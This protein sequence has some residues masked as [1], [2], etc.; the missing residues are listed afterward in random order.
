MLD[1]SSVTLFVSCPFTSSISS[2]GVWNT[3]GGITFIVF[4][5]VH[6]SGISFFLNKKSIH[7]VYVNSNSLSKELSFISIHKIHRINISKMHL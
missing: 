1:N 6:I 3:A 4:K 5:D 7:T 2:I